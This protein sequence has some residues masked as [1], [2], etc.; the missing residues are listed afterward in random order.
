MSNI[1]VARLPA[2]F[3][4]TLFIEY[5][6]TRNG[7]EDVD[8]RVSFGGE[9]VIMTKG[10]LDGMVKGAPAPIVI[11][12]IDIGLLVEDELQVDVAI[13]GGPWKPIVRKSVAVGQVESLFN[14]SVASAPL[15]PS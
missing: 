5:V 10:Q 14:P 3:R 1:V 6:P 13:A 12:P 7:K 2:N 15:P 9:E 11:G 4:F 8:F